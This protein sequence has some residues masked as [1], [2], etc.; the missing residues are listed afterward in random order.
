MS[1][2]LNRRVSVSTIPLFAVLVVLLSPVAS[3]AQSYP[4][5]PVSLVNRLAHP[6]SYVS[7]V[8]CNK[9]KWNQLLFSCGD[10]CGTFDGKTARDHAMIQ[11]EQD[12]RTAAGCPI[13][14]PK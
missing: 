1:R 5:Q 4:L 12:C 3:L 2:S 14:E 10:K 8:A 11:C 7:L 9:A 6:Q 13:A